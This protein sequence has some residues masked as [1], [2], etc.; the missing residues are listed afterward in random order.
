[1]QG[2]QGCQTNRDDADKQRLHLVSQQVQLALF[3]AVQAAFAFQKQAC[4]HAELSLH[5]G[6][7]MLPSLHWK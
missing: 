4:M 1:M 5:A 2:N 3:D 7:E 6:A